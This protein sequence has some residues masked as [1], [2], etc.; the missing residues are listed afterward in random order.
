MSN[1]ATHI[2]VSVGP[3]GADATQIQ[4]LRDW[5]EGHKFGGGSNNQFLQRDTGDATYGAKWSTGLTY[6]G[7]TLSIASAIAIAGNTNNTITGTVAGAYTTTI[8]NSS[9]NAAAYAGLALT[10][11]SVSPSLLRAMSSAFTPVNGARADGAQWINSAGAGGL[12]LAA[13]H[14]SGVITFWTN[15]AE[16][17]RITAAGLLTFGGTSNAFPALK[18][19]SAD[20]Q[21]RLADDSAYATLDCLG[22]MASGAAGASFGPAAVASITVVNGIVTAIS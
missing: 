19:S 4:P 13:G 9:A 3:D 2:F 8:T 1:V 18:R 7:T 22:L 10:T 17:L 11:N 15:G 12:D 20:V 21:V 6:D 14:A 5:N 16:R